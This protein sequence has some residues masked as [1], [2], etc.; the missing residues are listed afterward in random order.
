MMTRIAAALLFGALAVSPG[1]SMAADESSSLET[2]IQSAKTPADHAALAQD[3]KAKAQEA[4]A[5][6]ERHEGMGS[7]GVK[8][9]CSGTLPE[10]RQK[11][12]GSPRTTM[13]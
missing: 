8:N 6:A 2:A 9:S 7:I 12:R 5:M 4:R 13:R 11:C 3:Y 10:H 1:L